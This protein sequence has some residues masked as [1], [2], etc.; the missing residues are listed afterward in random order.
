MEIYS[1]IERYECIP[2]IE[3]DVR[4]LQLGSDPKSAVTHA[5]P[6]LKFDKHNINTYYTTLYIEL[7]IGDE[8]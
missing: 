5:M 3:T 6:K 8:F 4:K 1:L 7:W 2:I